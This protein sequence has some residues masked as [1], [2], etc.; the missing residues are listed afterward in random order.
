[1][2]NNKNNNNRK[3]H[4]QRQQSVKCATPT[5]ISEQTINTANLYV[6]HTHRNRNY[7]KGKYKY[8]HAAKKYA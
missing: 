8:T 6:K 7:Q 3:I 1:M 4:L 5:T 2:Y